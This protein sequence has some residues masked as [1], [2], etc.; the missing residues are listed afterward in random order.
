MLILVGITIQSITNTGLFEGAKEVKKNIERKRI[1]EWLNSK[2]DETPIAIDESKT[3]DETIATIRQNIEEN[4]NE[5]G[6]DVR[7]EEI[8]N[9][10][11]GE[12]VE[13]Y[14]YTIVDK[15][16]YKVDFTGAKLIGKSG[17][18]FPVIN[19]KSITNTT[20]SIT[21]QV[22]TK[23][24]EGGKIEYYIREEDEEDYTLKETTTEEIYTYNGLEQDKKY[25]IKIVAVAENKET[26]EVYIDKTVY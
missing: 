3:S 22:T 10:E 16:I 18:L 6:K 24:N 11:D 19:I 2:L 1:V 5:L 9:E 12:Q 23:R 20:D 17:K 25:N 21:V 14:F 8:S 4:K 7:V 26:A 15:D 13:A